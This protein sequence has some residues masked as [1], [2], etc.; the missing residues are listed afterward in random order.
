M[1]LFYLFTVR[2]FVIYSFLILF[3]ISAYVE[4]IETRS[5]I[6]S[7]RNT[8]RIK[9]LGIWTFNY[10]FMRHF[11]KG[12]LRG[13]ASIDPASALQN[14]DYKKLPYPG[15]HDCKAETDPCLLSNIG[16]SMF[17]DKHT[18]S[19]LFRQTEDLSW[20]AR[21]NFLSNSIDMYEQL[22]TNIPVSQ[23]TFGTAGIG[24]VQL[25]MTNRLTQTK[26]MDINLTLGV[27]F[28]LGSIDETDGINDMLGE[29]GIAPYDMQLGSG[30]YDI[31]TELS[32]IGFYYGLKYGF[33]ISLTSPTGLNNQY[34]N[35]GDS[36]KIKGWSNYTF[37]FGTQ[38]RVGVVQNVQSPIEG[39]D[40]RLS[41]NIRYSGGKRL[42][43][44]VGLGQKF[45]GFGIF[46]DYAHPLLQYAN[47]VQM[48]TTG[49]VSGNIEYTY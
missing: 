19:I 29:E 20:T 8:Y 14:P 15:S 44:L 33:D 43:G 4:A 26:R 18:F 34:Y 35:R 10:S 47:G 40:E 28:P 11:K 45:K 1:K 16:N 42:D 32:L 3:G 39:R 37:S 2:K 49:I 24:D 36:L 41:D 48:K 25:L 7:D 9:N 38:L 31:I 21:F 46:V 13:K 30:T 6:S 22:S 23:F 5:T 27:N 17:M 12:V